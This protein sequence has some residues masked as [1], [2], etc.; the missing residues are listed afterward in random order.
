[1][2]EKQLDLDVD[3]ILLGFKN[4]LSCKVNLSESVEMVLSLYIKNRI[5]NLKKRGYRIVDIMKEIHAIDGV[6]V[7]R[8]AVI[9]RYRE[10][11]N[12]APKPRPGR[13][14]ILQQNI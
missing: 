9:K 6:K 11:G 1:M 5:V 10:T 7:G 2:P 12:L 14:P 3:C 13:K 4:I 8:N